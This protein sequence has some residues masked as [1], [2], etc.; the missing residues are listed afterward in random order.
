M[1]NN[2][3]KVD[4]D[5]LYLLPSSLQDWVPANHLPRFV[6]ELVD[7]L[8]L[9]VL[10]SGNRGSGKAACHPSVL[11]SLLFCGFATGVLSNR[12]L[13]Q[14]NFNSV[15]FL[16]IAGNMHPDNGTTAHFRKRFL[17]ELEGMFVPVLVLAK[18][19]GL[20]K[21]VH[22]N[23]DCTKAKIDS[24]DGVRHRQGGE[25]LHAILPPWVSNRT[26]RMDS[27]TDACVT[28]VIEQTEP[29]LP[30]EI[31]PFRRMSCLC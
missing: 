31:H 19:T 28:R 15:V 17:Q 3:C 16:F 13:E 1:S 6:V 12:K 24:G 23:L 27:E 4:R 9:G 21:L 7:H 5:T 20:L 8:D 30:G 26:R 29:M 11:L 25:G 22:V 2:F 10:E 18:E 14:A